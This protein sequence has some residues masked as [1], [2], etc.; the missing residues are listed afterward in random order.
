MTTTSPFSSN[1]QAS[2]HKLSIFLLNGALVPGIPF[3][4]HIIF[5]EVK[6]QPDPQFF[7]L[8]AL[9]SLARW[10]IFKASTAFGET[11]LDLALERSIR[12]FTNCLLRCSTRTALSLD[13]LFFP[14]MTWIS[15]TI[16]NSFL[17]RLTRSN[18]NI[19]RAV[20]YF[21]NEMIAI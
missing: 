17:S 12:N 3:L 6:V 20:F 14:R 21:L 10:K 4:V 2:V 16:A 19:Y 18:L 9:N 15:P 13:A 11:L 7:L 5:L 8:V 1:V